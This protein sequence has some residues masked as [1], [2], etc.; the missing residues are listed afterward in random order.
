GG[1]EIQTNL[2]RILRYTRFGTIIEE[3]ILNILA[4]I[5]RDQHPYRKFFSK[6]PLIGRLMLNDQIKLLK[7]AQSGILQ[8]F[9][10][11]TYFKLNERYLERF[12]SFDIRRRERIQN[13]LIQLISRYIDKQGR[14]DETVFANLGNNLN[15]LLN[16]IDTF[17][18]YSEYFASTDRF[19][20][21]RLLANLDRHFVLQTRFLESLENITHDLEIQMRAYNA[22]LQNQLSED[23]LK[24]IN[25]LIRSVVLRDIARGRISEANLN[26]INTMIDNILRQRNL[27][28][29]QIR[30][31][32]NL[33]SNTYSRL[34]ENYNEHLRDA[35][36]REFQYR[37]ISRRT[38]DDLAKRL[39]SEYAHLAD[40]I[41][42]DMILRR[43]KI[44]RFTTS[45]LN[46]KIYKSLETF[47]LSMAFKSFFL[48]KIPFIGPALASLGFPWNIVIGLLIAPIIYKR[49]AIISFLVRQ[50]TP[51]LQRGYEKVQQFIARY[52]P[53]SVRNLFDTVITNARNIINRFR[54][55]W[56]WNNSLMLRLRTVIGSSVGNIIRSILGF[57]LRQ[58][59]QPT[60]PEVIQRAYSD[61]TEQT[62]NL[63]LQ[64]N[65]NNIEAIIERLREVI[66][67][68]NNVLSATIN[69]L[70]SALANLTNALNNIRNSIVDISPI[71]NAITN[72]QNSIVQTLDNIYTLLYERLSNI[73]NH[74]K[75]IPKV[76]SNI[77][78]TLQ[79]IN[80]TKMDETFTQGL[81][82]NIRLISQTL[83][84]I[85]I[86]SSSIDNRLQILDES[87]N[88]LYKRYTIKRDG[89]DSLKVHVTNV[90]ELCKCIRNN[91]VIPPLPG[92]SS[93]IGSSL[94]GY[95]DPIS[96]L[97]STLLHFAPFLLRGAGK[98]LGLGWRG[99]KWLGRKGWQGLKWLG[100][101]GME[102]LRW[103]GNKG[104]QGLRW[105][106]TK[107][108]EL[109]SRA[110]GSNL[111]RNI[112]S[113]NLVRSAT[114]TL[115]RI[116]LTRASG[117]IIGSLIGGPIGLLA[118]LALPVVAGY[119]A[120]KL[121]RKNNAE[122]NAAETNVNDVNTSVV[123]YDF[124]SL[125]NI[126]QTQV[127]HQKQTNAIL[128][129]VHNTLQEIHTTIKDLHY[130]VKTRQTDKRNT[131]GVVQ[132]NNA[133]NV[134]GQNSQLATEDRLSRLKRWL[135]F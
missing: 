98:L 33:V 32:L 124:T 49:G 94:F 39:G 42:R 128:N 82:D 78:N 123:Q 101:K 109:I 97:L 88:K 48:F 105:I 54:R 55:S 36:E 96:M 84:N 44:F 125:Y 116:T 90:D 91:N 12:F 51:V 19:A 133:I 79:N 75:T 10:Q 69:N 113:S 23:T 20:I 62:P 13:Q 100:R 122:S 38:I 120:N 83:E 115:G 81:S 28:E 135:G 67:N 117:A 132:S 66:D 86:H 106:G 74:I 7:A 104:K 118:G 53:E 95:G 8:N 17:N 112:A 114:N 64:Q 6:I 35:I 71:T 21:N 52:V 131:A 18:R 92:M 93:F 2:A 85:N 99:L 5:D 63:H 65:Q 40:E 31:F 37:G 1:E 80:T 14:I 70:N 16:Y 102:G 60:Q 59:S 22:T 11:T 77:Q 30:V 127:E 29:E 57:D 111:A 130:T 47:A 50:L 72:L 27:S 58:P 110:A 43:S 15:R 121:F 108:S 126:L 34:A 68:V 107:G 25:N 87:L 61:V 9:I 134:T 3:D 41:A 56:F 4:N 24:D 26:E 76:L 46:N 103:L 89:I 129:N 73:Q 119:A 45:L